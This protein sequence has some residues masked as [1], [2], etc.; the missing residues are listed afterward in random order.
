MKYKP[1]PKYKDSGVEWLGKVPEH[2]VPKPMRYVCKLNPPVN[3]TGVAEVDELTFLPMDRVKTGYY[4]PNTAQFSK[5]N[6]SYNPFE[7]GDIVLAKVTP[8]FENGN[9]AITE[10]LVGG[11]GFGSSELFVIRPTGTHRKFLFYFLQSSVFKQHGEASMTGAGGLKRVSPEL[12]RQSPLPFPPLEEQQAIAAFLDRETARID[13]LI[14]KK[15]RLIE[16]LKE[17]RQAII[18]RAVTKGLDPNVPMK[19]SGVEW[20][21]KVPAHWR[22]IPFLK[23]MSSVVDYRGRT[24]EK[25]DDGVFL[26][27]ARNI[28]A[29][30][31]NY[32]S[33]MEYTTEQ[34]YREIIKRGTAVS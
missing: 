4:I 16:L 34:D 14:E 17:K 8:C 3:F 6:S 20:L 18:T 12:L 2:W 22:V 23:C 13:A 7:E 24:P 9:I 15:Q 31:L 28:G 29:G 25:V 30:R 26:L 33:S 11:K 27:T 5:Y 21:G 1:Y 10:N 19:D 32:L